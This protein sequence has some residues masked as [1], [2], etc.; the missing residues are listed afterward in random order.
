M[1]KDEWTIQNPNRRSVYTRALPLILSSDCQGCITGLLDTTTVWSPRLARIAASFNRKFQSL[2]AGAQEDI[3]R[4]SHNWR[5]FPELTTAAD[6]HAFH[7]PS[8]LGHDLPGQLRCRRV[9][10]RR[11]HPLREGDREWDFIGSFLNLFTLSKFNKTIE[12]IK[13]LMVESEFTINVLY[14]SCH[15]WLSQHWRNPRYSG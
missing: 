8:L 1:Y 11:H 3:R 9:H 6:H 7:L 15:Q 2:L 14:F 10:A 4:K 13:W 5:K 12:L